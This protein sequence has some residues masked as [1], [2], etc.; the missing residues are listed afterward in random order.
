M[1][2]RKK[3]KTG[4][5]VLSKGTIVCC[6]VLIKTL[7]SP[8]CLQRLS[9]KFIGISCAYINLE[10]INVH[11]GELYHIQSIYIRFVGYRV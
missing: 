9:N 6:T 8:K 4:D 10:A 7:Y 5:V 3:P 2:N 1:E 11:N